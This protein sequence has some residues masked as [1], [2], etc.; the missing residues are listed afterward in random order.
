MPPPER[1]MSAGFARKSHTPRGAPS[2]DAVT[3]C[4]P[5]AVKDADLTFPSLCPLRVTKVG[6]SPRKSHT[7]AVLS[8]H[9]FRRR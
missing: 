3:T 8:S 1:R 9:A 4:I 5:S 2:S 7:R 6:R